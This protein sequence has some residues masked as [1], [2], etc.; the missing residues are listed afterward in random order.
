[1]SLLAVVGAPTVGTGAVACSPVMMTTVPDWAARGA[2]SG[3]ADSTSGTRARR[4]RRIVVAPGYW[5][6]GRTH[7]R[8]DRGRG[9]P[10]VSAPPGPV[11]RAE[12]QLMGRGG[13]EDSF[14]G[15]R[16]DPRGAHHSDDGIRNLRE[17][18]G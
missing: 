5:A 16:L 14:G 7:G 1:R 6:T 17:P 12:L 11:C 18:D 13:G 3:P 4:R 8:Y 9:L 10:S 2:A 15:G